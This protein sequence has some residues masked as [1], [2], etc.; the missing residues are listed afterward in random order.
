MPLCHPLLMAAPD[1]PWWSLPPRG[2]P[3]C[4]TAAPASRDFG[5]LGVSAGYQREEDRGLSPGSAQDLDVHLSWLG[6]CFG[7]W[8]SVRRGHPSSGDAGAAQGVDGP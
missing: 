3:S 2:G 8:G 6:G 4:P 5:K 1:I 7:H